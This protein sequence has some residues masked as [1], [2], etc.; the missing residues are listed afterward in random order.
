V[1]ETLQATGD[2]D[3]VLMD[4][5]TPGLDGYATAAAIRDIPGFADLPVIAVTARAMRSDRD[6]APATTSPSPSA[7]KSSSPAWSAGS[8]PVSDR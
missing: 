2:I 6:K 5:M 8:A 3:I 1:P 7:P 4:V